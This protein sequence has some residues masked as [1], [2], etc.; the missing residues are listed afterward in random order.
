MYYIITAKFYQ[1]VS[2]FCL[3]PA[4]NF[5]EVSEGQQWAGV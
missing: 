1:D 5:P 3:F 4:E 2:V